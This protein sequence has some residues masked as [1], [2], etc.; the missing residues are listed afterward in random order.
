MAIPNDFLF[1]QSSGLYYKDEM[2]VDQN[3]VPIRL[4]TWYD[5]NTDTYNPVAY[6][7]ENTANTQGAEQE[8]QNYQQD[9]TTQDVGNNQQTYT[10]NS[11]YSENP[12]SGQE[13]PKKGKGGLIAIIASSSCA[14]VIAVLAIVGWQLGWFNSFFG[15]G[16]NVVSPDSTATPM[17]TSTP[18]P[19]ALAQ[20]TPTPIPPT[21]TPA[22]EPEPLSTSINIDEV[23]IFQYL[24]SSTDLDM[25]DIFI[26]DLLSAYPK[27]LPGVEAGDLM[28]SWEFYFG[29]YCAVSLYYVCEETNSTDEILISD[30]TAAFWENTADGWVSIY[31]PEFWAGAGN[32]TFYDLD[33]PPE[34]QLLFT[35]YESI[36]TYIQLGTDTV[37]RDIPIVSEG[38]ETDYHLGT[39]YSYTE[40]ILD[41]QYIPYIELYDDGTCYVMLNM[42]NGMS[43]GECTYTYYPET[44]DGYIYFPGT[45]E[46]VYFFFIDGFNTLIFDRVENFGILNWEYY[47]GYSAFFKE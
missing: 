32:I 14:V 9:P 24:D 46:E 28:Y 22:P 36:Y 37:D 21:A 7:V 31:T 6:P 15:G 35:E 1:D 43:G 3:N 30:M 29:N 10:N 17:L 2:T 5:P 40:L 47:E 20:A 4:V 27:S 11:Y 41:A 19:T 18:A 13:P 44:L 16:D 8:P 12:N 33:L 34:P 25:L 23:E 39:Y 45:D 42:G 38:G 26:P